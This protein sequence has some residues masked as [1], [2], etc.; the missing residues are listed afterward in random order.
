MGLF[1][2]IYF[3]IYGGLHLYVF[4]KAWQAF[5]FHHTLGSVIC[6]VFVLMIISPI[7]VRFLERE[8]MTPWRVSSLM[9]DIPGWV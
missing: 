3:L 7:I 6:S 4:L 2:I 5:R 8:G 9:R 1:L